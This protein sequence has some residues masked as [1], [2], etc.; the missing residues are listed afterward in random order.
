M[1]PMMLSLPGYRV[2]RLNFVALAVL[3]LLACANRAAGSMSTW[4]GVSST[5]WNTSANWVGGA[6]TAGFVALFDSSPYANQPANSGGSG[7]VGAIWETGSSAALTISGTSALTLTGTTVGPNSGVGIELDSGAGG[8]TISAPLTVGGAQRWLANSAYPLT[9]SGNILGSAALTTSGAGTVV[10][11]G[12]DSFSTTLTSYSNLT[13]T[14]TVNVASGNF[15]VS[16]GLF[17]LSGGSFTTNGTAVIGNGPAGTAANMLVSGGT[18]GQAVANLAIGQYA[19]GILTINGG[20]MNLGK[21]ILSFDSGNHGGAG[22]LNLNGGELD[23]GQ[24]FSSGGTVINTVNFNG[25]VLKLTG[26]VAN[27]LVNSAD[28]ATNVGNGG[29]LID[30]NGFRT[31]ISNNLLNS[32][33]TTSGGLTLNSVSGGTLALSGSNTYAGGTFIKTGTLIVDSAAS[34]PAGSNLTLGQ[35]AMSAFAASGNSS[36]GYSQLP[37]PLPLASPAE[38]VAVPESGTLALLSAALGGVVIH[39]RLRRPRDVRMRSR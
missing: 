18:Y 29:V 3:S 13:S 11:S 10:L 39:C 25:G 38:V 8:L 31:E 14:G 16:A 23:V 28:F 1:T 34:L 22:T 12:S 26:S 20:L 21:T 15:L 36:P 5:A 37:A 35:G 2:P 32:G 19:P 4:S 17:T 6:P 24:P 30:L 9:I 7:S 33:G 27:L